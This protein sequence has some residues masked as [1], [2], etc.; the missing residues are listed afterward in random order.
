M[1]ITHQ[2]ALKVERTI[3][4][5]VETNYLLFLP[6]DYQAK[7]TQRWPMILFLHGAGERG[8]NLAKVTIHGPP[9]IVKDRPDFPFILVSP[10]C[11]PGQVWDNDTLLMLLDEVVRKHKVDT[12]RIYLTGLSMGGYGAWS[13][14][15]AHPER[16][17]AIAPIC[18]GGDIIHVLLASRTK[19]QALK[20]LPVWAF[21]GAKD[22]IVK[23]SESERMVSALKAAGCQEVNLKVY[24]EAGHDAWTETYNNP[25]L[26]EWFLK[27]RRKSSAG[28]QLGS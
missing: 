23:V 1:P 27:H 17:A 5:K 16:F 21:H 20:T 13:L 7:G 3:K 6:K 4:K 18:G 10:Q 9:K 12:K 26:Y 2:K 24:P 8:T 19:A 15:T 25:E 11:S 22:P 14:G 28:A